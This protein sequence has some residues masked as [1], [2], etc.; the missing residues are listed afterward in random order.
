MT[1][2][3]REDIPV[4]AAEDGSFVREL[5]HTPTHSLAEI[6]HPAGTASR[7]HYHL[8]A[9][10][11]YYV[12]DGH[13]EIRV[14]GETSAVGP[15]DVISIGPGRRHQVWPKG[16]EYLLLLVTCSPPYDPAELAFTGS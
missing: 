8:T 15:G 14:D 2:K 12:L 3:N 10:E 1:I 6:R 13:G 16:R 5:A 4:M 9:D 7:E 11:V